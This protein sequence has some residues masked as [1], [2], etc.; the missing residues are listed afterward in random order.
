MSLGPD[1]RVSGVPVARYGF[2]RLGGYGPQVRRELLF[3]AGI[4]SGTQGRLGFIPDDP[5]LC[6]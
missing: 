1:R 3:R 6:Q 4:T 2:K 5:G